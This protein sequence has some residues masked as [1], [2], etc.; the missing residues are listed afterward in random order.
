V[1]STKKKSNLQRLKEKLKEQE[2]IEQP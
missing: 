1:D 2:S